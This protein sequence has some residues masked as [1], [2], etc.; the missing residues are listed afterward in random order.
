MTINN[1]MPEG[2][3]NELARIHKAKLIHMHE[4]LMS[5]FARLV[6][7]LYENQDLDRMMFLAELVRCMSMGFMFEDQQI[8]NEL[9]EYEKNLKKDINLDDLEF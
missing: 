6:D 3:A 4:F 2:D 8:N 9:W 7:G 1:E 5:G